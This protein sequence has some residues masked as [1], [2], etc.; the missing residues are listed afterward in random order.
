[1]IKKL[2]PIWAITAVCISTQAAAQTG[3]FVDPNRSNE[4]TVAQLKRLPDNASLV[5]KGN[6]IRQVRGDVYE[7]RDN[8][9]SVEIEIDN[10]YWNGQNV[11]S[12]ETVR[13]LIE[14]DK[15]VMDTDYDVKAP[16]E[17]LGVDAAQ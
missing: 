15:D 10:K 13:L 6:I 17:I 2:L 5:V 11:T 1:M 7:F 3:G 4:G 14:V 8:T 16:V 9:G 12:K